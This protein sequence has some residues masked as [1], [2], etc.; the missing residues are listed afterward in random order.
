MDR[1][2]CL[3]CGVEWEQPP[4]PTAIGRDRSAGCWWWEERKSACPVCPSRYARWLDG[5]EP[6]PGVRE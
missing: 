1:F 3:A 2:R 4:M 5:P 6:F